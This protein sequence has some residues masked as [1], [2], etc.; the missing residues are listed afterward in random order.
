[1]DGAAVSEKLVDISHNM[2]RAVCQQ[3]VSV[4]SVTSDQ[5]FIS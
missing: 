3:Y 5:C 2:R 4:L 1:M